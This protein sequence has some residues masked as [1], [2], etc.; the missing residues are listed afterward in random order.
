[1][2]D[3]V[4]ITAGSG[5]TIATDDIGGGVQVQRVKLTTGA[6]GTATDV[7]TAAPAPVVGMMT[8]GG[9]VSAQTAAGGTTYTAFA[10]QACKQATIVN[11]TGT[12][13]LVQQGGAGVGIPIWDQTVFSFFG[14]T[15]MSN[16]GI[17]RKDDS[18]SQVTVQARWE[19]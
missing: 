13:I 10:S 2:A 16:L 19:S 5:V 15:N 7:S 1:M 3:N 9:N 8:S 11:D 12:T 14:L 17:K 6:D 18:T 4:S